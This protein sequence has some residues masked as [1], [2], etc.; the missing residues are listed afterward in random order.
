VAKSSFRH[1]SPPVVLHHFGNRLIL[2]NYK[3]LSV[4]NQTCFDSLLPQTNCHMRD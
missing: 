4:A 1:L 2:L 3:D